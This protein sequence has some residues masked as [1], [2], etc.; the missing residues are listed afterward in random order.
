M[1]TV[2]EQMSHTPVGRPER[3]CKGTLLFQNYGTAA[4]MEVI[5]SILL[6][7]KWKFRA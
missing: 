5:F 6:M 2:A 7:E 4:G 1:H 3:G